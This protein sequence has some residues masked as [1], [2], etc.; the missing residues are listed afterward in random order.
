M[1]LTGKTFRIGDSEFE[2]GEPFPHGGWGNGLCYYVHEYFDDGDGRTD[3]MSAHAIRRHLARAE[4]EAEVA[5]A[6]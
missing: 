4:A 6:K 3:Y 5:A 1:K 2:V